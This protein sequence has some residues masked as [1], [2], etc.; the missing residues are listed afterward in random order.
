MGKVLPDCADV[1]NV[2][3][4]CAECG[5][6]KANP[7]CRGEGEKPVMVELG[8]IL[9][10]LGPKMLGEMVCDECVL[11]LLG[12]CM[13]CIVTVLKVGRI[14]CPSGLMKEE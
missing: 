14:M 2:R 12:Y 4:D 9:K 11:P 3:L 10:P 7:L 8:E 1:G 6:V 13:V 5:V